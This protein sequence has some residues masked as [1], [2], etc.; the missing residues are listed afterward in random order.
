MTT[1]PSSKPIQL[2]HAVYEGVYGPIVTSEVDKDQA[3][4]TIAIWWAEH[5]DANNDTSA[6]PLPTPII[7][8]GNRYY[9]F[10]SDCGAWLTTSFVKIPG[11]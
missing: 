11:G 8:G 1:A 9:E 6:Q 10:D 3:L 2:W 7:V 5:R 4:T